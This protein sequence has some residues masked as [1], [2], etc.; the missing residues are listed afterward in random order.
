MFPLVI[1]S[2][3]LGI[4]LDQYSD[5]M[6]KIV[7]KDSLIDMHGGTIN[8]RLHQA[9]N[10]I[11][12]TPTKNKTLTLWFGIS[13]QKRIWVE[14]EEF[15]PALVKQLKPWFD[16]FIFLIDGFTQMNA[17]M[18]MSMIP[19]VSKE[20]PKIVNSIKQNLLHHLQMPQS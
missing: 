3:Q 13:G 18:G 10:T 15:L 2:N 12:K 5:A 11:I 8:Y 16:S 6:E 14:Q 20:N 17:L 1:G 7:Y 4:K 19:L 9:I